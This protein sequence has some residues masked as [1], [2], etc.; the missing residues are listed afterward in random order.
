VRYLIEARTAGD[1]RGEERALGTAMVL[2]TAASLL[3]AGAALVCADWWW[4]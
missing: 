1:R 4:P 2:A 3:V